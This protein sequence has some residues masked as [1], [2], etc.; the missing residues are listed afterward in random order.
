MSSK[1]E[2]HHHHHHHHHQHNHLQ[3]GSNL[4]SNTIQ[5]TDT[6]KLPT[7]K[8]EDAQVCSTPFH[9]HRTYASLVL[10]IS[11]SSPVKIEVVDLD[12]GNPGIPR[13]SPKLHPDFPDVPLP[14][15]YTTVPQQTQAIHLV[16]NASDIHTPK[17]HLEHGENDHTL[18][19]LPQTPDH[20]QTHDP[21][22]G[23]FSSVAFSPI[24]IIPSST[25]IPAQF[26]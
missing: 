4:P 12:R 8:A 22:H 20:I 19:P 14:L 25:Y 17:E 26:D 5:D 15:S 23:T 21:S 16:H 10:Q 24:I 3:N 18:I 7:T 1:T 13:S 6:E 9:S 2:I 11:L